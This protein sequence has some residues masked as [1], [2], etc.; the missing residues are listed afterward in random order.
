M[1]QTDPLLYQ[2][3]R[4]QPWAIAIWP[5]VG[6]GILGRLRGI[7][8]SREDLKPTSTHWVDSTC[9]SNPRSAQ[10]VHWGTVRSRPNALFDRQMHPLLRMWGTWTAAAPHHHTTTRPR[11]SVIDNRRRR[12]QRTPPRPPNQCRGVEWSVKRAVIGQRAA[13]GTLLR[14]PKVGRSWGVEARSGPGP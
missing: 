10:R 2:W 9:E 1:I 5:R 3:A 11:S 13:P 4:R 8:T 6:V 14:E 12:P 7:L